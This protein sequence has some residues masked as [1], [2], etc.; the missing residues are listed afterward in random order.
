MKRAAVVVLSLVFAVS[1]LAWAGPGGGKRA[2]GEGKKARGEVAW[3]LGSSSDSQTT[4][5]AGGK[6]K[7]KR[8]RQRL[9]EQMQS[10]D[11]AGSSSNQ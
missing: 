7:H 1:S 8:D 6:R 10:Q 4:C 9:H 11:Q 3:Q 5:P 2:G